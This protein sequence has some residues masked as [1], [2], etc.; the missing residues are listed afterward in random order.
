MT[1]VLGNVDHAVIILHISAEMA[2]SFGYSGGKIRGGIPALRLILQRGRFQER[3]QPVVPDLIGQL[4]ALR[5]GNDGYD[6][7]EQADRQHQSQH[8]RH[9]P[10]PETP[11]QGTLP[12]PVL[13]CLQFGH[14]DSLL[15]RICRL[16]SASIIHETVLICKE[17]AQPAH[18]AQAVLKEI[19]R[20]N[21]LRRPGGRPFPSCPGRR[22]RR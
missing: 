20:I 1:A 18:I 3:R 2:E 12:K 9:Q 22:G 6:H 13:P 10:G 11:E 5:D 14:Q 16:G 15:A 4:T 8:H 17:K 19:R 7:A 21:P